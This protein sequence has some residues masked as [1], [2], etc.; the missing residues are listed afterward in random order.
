MPST[1]YNPH[2]FWA[3]GFFWAWLEIRYRGF[4]L[5]LMLREIIRGF[6]VL[7]L[8]AWRLLRRLKKPRY[9]LE[10]ACQQRGA[11]CTQILADPPSG[12]KKRRVLLQIFVWF[13]RWLHNFHLRARGPE[14]ELVFRCGYLQPSGRCGI[15]RWRPRLCRVYP[16]LPFF[17]A[18]KL[19]PGCGYRTRLRGLRAHPKLPILGGGHVGVHHPTPLPIDDGRLER[20]ED[21]VLVD[22]IPKANE[23]RR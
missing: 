20:K 23:V 8:S 18:P 14:G 9:V 13:H 6:V 17:A 1:W 22:N 11:C 4:L 10:G 7:D 21:F 19:L 15:Y 2:L 3:L 12:I 5:K 16:V